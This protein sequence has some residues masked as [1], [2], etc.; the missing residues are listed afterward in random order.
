[1]HLFPSFWVSAY[2]IG[3]KGALGMYCVNIIYIGWTFIRI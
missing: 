2:E 3:E 1:M